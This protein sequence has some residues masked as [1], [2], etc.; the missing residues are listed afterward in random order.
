M[1]PSPTVLEEVRVPGWSKQKDPAP[2]NCERC[3]RCTVPARL[4][5]SRA[6]ERRSSDRL[7]SHARDVWLR[8]GAVPRPVHDHKPPARALAS[9]KSRA[10]RRRR[11]F[12]STR[13]TGQNRPARRPRPP[14]PSVRSSPPPYARSLAARPLPA[15]LRC[16]ARGSARSRPGRTWRL[17]TVVRRRRCPRFSSRSPSSSGAPCLAETWG[18]CTRAASE[19]GLGFVVLVD[20]S[21]LA[22]RGEIA[23]EFRIR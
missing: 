23:R 9:R 8:S 6:A 22:D 3:A 19:A 17:A 2:R 7:R 14:V 13:E 11:G 18:P 15:H 10:E 4:C 16:G 12:H 5:L 1:R 20:G 21:R